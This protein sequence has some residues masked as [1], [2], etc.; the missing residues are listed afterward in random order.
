MIEP[1]LVAPD[2]LQEIDVGLSVSDSADLARLGLDPRHAQLAIGELTRAVL[3]AGGRVVYGGRIKP[4][5]F[6]QQLMGEVRRYGTS[7]HSLT[8][9][10]ALPEHLKLTTAEL[11]TLDRDLGTWGRVILLDL[12][13]SPMPW[14]R[15]RPEHPA[16]LEPNDRA[17]AYSSLRRF[18]TDATRARVLV[19]GQLR[20]YQGAM[21][22]LLEEAI[23]S[24][25]REQPLY[26]AGGFGGA[27]A[28]IAQALG[29]PLD[30]LPPDAPEGH[31]DPGVEGSV[32]RLIDIAS[33]S[34]WSADRDGLT[35]A[36]RALL[37]ASHRPA[38]IASL[39]VLG[40]ARRF[41]DGESDGTGQET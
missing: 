32:A 38:D 28:L 9:C 18:I 35:P 22:G 16:E 34:G 6:T 40:M 33:S 14:P 26:V 27:S 25:E 10:L 5:G 19:G 8:I 30:W 12:D 20:G 7:R 31:G 36:E 24:I 29:L 2:A 21:P 17:V 37:A 1:T 39:A 11:D 13:G 3:I 4:S 41:S 15:D 23:L